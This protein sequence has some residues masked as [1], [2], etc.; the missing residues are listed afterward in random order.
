MK[1]LA[2]LFLGLSLLAPAVSLAG[3]PSQEEV[4]NALKD[5]LRGSWKIVDV[6]EVE[7][8]DLCAVVVKSGLRSVVLYVDED[9][10]YL[11]AGNLFDLK[12]KK[13]LTAELEE[14]Y[15]KVSPEILKKLEKLTDYT[16][17]KGHDKYIYFISDPD[18]PYCRRT[19]PILEEWAKRNGVEVRIIFFPLPIH[20]NAKPK[21]I[22][23]IC[24][25]NKKYEEIHSDFEPKNLC[26]E[27]KKKVEENIKYLS[28]I[29][30]S[31][32][33]TLIGMNGKVIPGLPRSE[34]DLNK[35]IK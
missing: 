32:T 33:P 24:S 21:A 3:C 9:L 20:P 18:C 29:G 19:A 27:G 11:F 12:A 22:D 2:T 31:G 4:K 16:Y 34:E 5:V 35:L 6:K 14:K 1:K 17:N 10:K 7:D 13:N 28:K 23:I 8:L 15:A 26:E 25:K 30:V